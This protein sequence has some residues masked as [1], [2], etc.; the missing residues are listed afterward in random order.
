MPNRS[1]K[2]PTD[3]NQLAKLIVDIASGEAEDVLIDPQSGKNLAAVALGR[4]GGLKGGVARAQ[5]LSSEERS[6]IAKNAAKA[7]W[8]RDAE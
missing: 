2:R 1:S 6:R 5:N 8:K 7:R 4:K 3:P